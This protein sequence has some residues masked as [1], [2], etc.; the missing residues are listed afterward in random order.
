MRSADQRGDGVW[1]NF[2]KHLIVKYMTVCWRG[3]KD[4]LL[5]YVVLIRT[6][7]HWIHKC[8]ST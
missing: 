3:Q 7:M 8:V 4:V 6:R 2:T 5:F 1:K